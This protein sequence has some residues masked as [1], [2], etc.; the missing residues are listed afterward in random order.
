VVE[1]ESDS[2]V[3]VMAKRKD[4]NIA[5]LEA[6]KRE[7]ILNHIKLTA[8]DNGYKPGTPDLRRR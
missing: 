7:G 1:K 8:S 6:W 3:G 5:W 2:Q 4:V